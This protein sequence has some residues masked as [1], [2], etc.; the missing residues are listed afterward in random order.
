MWGHTIPFSVW[1]PNDFASVEQASRIA[2]CAYSSTFHLILIQYLFFYCSNHMILIR[3]SDGNG[4]PTDFEMTFRCNYQYLTFVVTWCREI[5]Q[6]IVLCDCTLRLKCS[7][8]ILKKVCYNN[9]STFLKNLKHN[10]NVWLLEKTLS[11]TNYSRTC[12]ERPYLLPDIKK[13]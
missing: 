9:S 11:K 7:Y 13:V 10:N 8:Q 2:K 5:R 3:L 4:M 6:N 1:F 12:L